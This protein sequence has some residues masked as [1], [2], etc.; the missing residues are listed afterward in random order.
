[1]GKLIWDRPGRLDAFVGF[2]YWLNKFGNDPR[3]VQGSEEK[4]FLAGVS[5]HVF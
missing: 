5:I 2:Q 3:T 4:T 1:M